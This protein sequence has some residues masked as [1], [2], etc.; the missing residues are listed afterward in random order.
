MNAILNKLAA[1]RVIPV[2][3]IQNAD[4]AQPLAD[5]L[6]NGG[7]PCAEITFRTAAAAQAIHNMAQNKKMLV[8]A[9]TVL[10]I[11]QV[12][13]AV[14]AGAQFIVAPGF[15]DKVVGYCVKNNI[16]VTP[17]ICTP[18]DIERALDY[19]LDVVKFFP[20]EAF[21]GLITLKALSAPYNMMKFIPTGGIGVNNLAEYLAF[22]PV[23]ACGGSWMV[24]T[25]LICGG[26]F[27]LI[28]KLT[29]EAVDLA[30]QVKKS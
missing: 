12:K 3:A 24:K 16:P 21:G 22:P 1:I 8:G 9:G 26:K 28:A 18:T 7:L 14:D 6:C 13:A 25:D 30:S 4:D 27:D 15:S 29:R 17:G 10:K 11:D 2:V 5:A 20:A 19:D 23:L